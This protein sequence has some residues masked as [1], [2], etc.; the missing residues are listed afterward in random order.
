MAD[1]PDI[2]KCKSCGAEIGWITSAVS[3]KAMPVDLVRRSVVTAKGE[4]VVGYESH[5]SSCPTAD[6]HRG[7]R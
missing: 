3:G 1:R 5:W 6:Q 2:G 7:K 4:T